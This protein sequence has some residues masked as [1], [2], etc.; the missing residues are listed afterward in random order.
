M[1]CCDVQIQT[2]AVVTI[3]LKGSVVC[4]ARNPAE[5]KLLLGCS[6]GSL[7]SSTS[8]LLHKQKSVLM[9]KR[10]YIGSTSDRMNLRHRL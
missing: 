3:P 9:V 2:A 4:Q 6:D 5:D 8:H 1:L 10:L 7:V